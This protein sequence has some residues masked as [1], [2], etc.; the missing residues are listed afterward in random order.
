[1]I[2]VF[3]SVPSGHPAQSHL[4]VLSPGARVGWRIK[5]P[6]RRPLQYAPSSAPCLQA[7]RL[8]REDEDGSQSSQDELQ[9]KQSR[10]SERYS[11]WG[12]FGD[13]RDGVDLGRIPCFGAPGSARS[14]LKADG[15]LT[16]WPCTVC[17]CARPRVHEHTLGF[18]TET[19]MWVH[20]VGLGAVLREELAR[21][22]TAAWSCCSATSEMAA[23]NCVCAH[24]RQTDR[25]TGRENRE[26]GRERQGL[27]VSEAR[28]TVRKELPAT[29]EEEVGQSFCFLNFEEPSAFLPAESYSLVHFL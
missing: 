14:C 23:A 25:Q 20:L 21:G 11:T 6:K 22:S 9:S 4:S 27:A 1:M 28:A 15:E 5:A 3:S 7:Q 19:G 18:C 2:Q 16:G 10:G 29:L 13:L 26:G 8:G 17:V 12:T 24:A